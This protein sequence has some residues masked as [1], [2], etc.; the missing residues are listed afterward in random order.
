MKNILKLALA[1]TAIGAITI[2]G[3]A[4]EPRA[5]KIDSTIPVQPRIPALTCCEC[6]GKVTTLDLST[7]QSGPIDPLVENEQ[8]KRL[9]R[10]ESFGSFECMDGS[11]LG[12]LDSTGPSSTPS[13][14]IRPGYLQV[15]G[16]V[17]HPRVR[18]WQS[19]LNWTGKFS[20]DNSANAFLDVPLHSVCPCVGYC[21][22]GG[23]S[24]TPANPAWL[25][26]GSSHPGD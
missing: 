21:F 4:Q 10:F 16:E 9:C 25:H 2:V 17:L 23:A 15:H 18:H 19:D 11:A 20:A 13:T 3:L 24:L 22:Q 5:I 26:P 6:L 1:L 12:E 8:R 14:N 7:G